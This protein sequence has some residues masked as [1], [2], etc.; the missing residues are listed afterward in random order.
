MNRIESI[1]SQASRIV[2]YKIFYAK[3]INFP[4]HSIRVH[5]TP[6]NDLVFYIDS[7]SEDFM[8]SVVPVLDCTTMS[9]EEFF[10]YS[11]VWEHAIPIELVREVQKIGIQR[12]HA[13]TDL[14]D[15]LNSTIQVQY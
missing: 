6:Y 9:D 2:V 7:V 11:L 13:Y 8:A 4:E 15:S 10:Q 14:S 1:E 12:L 5:K 3:R